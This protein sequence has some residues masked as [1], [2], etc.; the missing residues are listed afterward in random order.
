MVGVLCLGTPTEA[1]PGTWKNVTVVTED[2]ARAQRLLPAALAPARAEP[3]LKEWIEIVV[4]VL[5]DF[6][7][8]RDIHD[9]VFDMLDDP[10]KWAVS[11]FADPPALP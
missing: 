8:G 2:E 3:I 9:R 5:F 11:V 1:L 10:D 6:L 4:T 7:F